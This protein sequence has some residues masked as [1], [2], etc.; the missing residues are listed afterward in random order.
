MAANMNPECHTATAGWCPACSVGTGRIVGRWR[1]RGVP[2][3]RRE[4]DSCGARYK[5]ERDQIENANGSR[6]VWRVMDVTPGEQLL[7]AAS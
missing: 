3:E 7:A 2:R 1:T 6:K 5:I 4:C